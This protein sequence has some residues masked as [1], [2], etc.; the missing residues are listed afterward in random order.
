MVNESGGQSPDMT[1]SA[2]LKDETPESSTLSC[3]PEDG[4]RGTQQGGSCLGAKRLRTKPTRQH[5]DVGL[6]ASRL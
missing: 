5:L 1:G 2:S 4:P 6:P 3:V